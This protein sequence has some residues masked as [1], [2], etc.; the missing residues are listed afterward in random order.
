MSRS[1]C[2][3]HIQRW[4][5]LIYCEK[6]FLSSFFFL[7]PVAPELGSV[8]AAPLTRSTGRWKQRL[9]QLSR[10]LC[11][12]EQ[13]PIASEGFYSL[14]ASDIDGNL[15]QFSRLRGR[16]VLIGNVASK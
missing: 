5:I 11:S 2:N 4:Q 16:A 8:M 3:N 1:A 9:G 7:D 12:S 10:C 15:L 13:G 14:S 6:L